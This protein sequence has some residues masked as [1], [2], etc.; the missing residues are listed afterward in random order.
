MRSPQQAGGLDQLDDAL[1]EQQSGREQD[2]QRRAV[3]APL[4]VGPKAG[5]VHAG[6][7]DQVRAGAA[8]QAGVGEG[9]PVFIVLEDDV[10]A[11]Q[12][13]AIEA[14]NGPPERSHAPRPAH[15]H[16][17][18]AGDGIDDLAHARAARRERAVE[19]A[20]DGEMVAMGRS[21]APVKRDQA[22]H[23][24]EFAERIDAVSGEVEG[25]PLEAV[26]DHE[27]GVRSRRGDQ[28]HLVAGVAHRARQRQ[29]EVVQVPVGVGEEQRRRL[30]GHRSR[31]RP[32]LRGGERLGQHHREGL[33][34]DALVEQVDEL[35][36]QAPQHVGGKQRIEIGADE[37]ELLV[38]HAQP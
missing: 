8:Q 34:G 24:A 11:A 5:D 1:F 23:R 37:I 35:L 30:P 12:Q 21:D 32:I 22:R 16:V 20:L 15:E 10:G 9:A 13:H 4:R 33:G 36:R 2:R 18:T 19:H 27:L 28:V 25:V 6:A 29:A 17:S 14:D 3:E 26:R 38:V 7:A 31:L